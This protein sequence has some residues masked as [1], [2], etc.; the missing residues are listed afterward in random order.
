MMIMTTKM[1]RSTEAVPRPCRVLNLGTE[2]YLPRDPFTRSP[3]P[4]HLSL[5]PKRH[6]HSYHILLVRHSPAYLQVKYRQERQD[7]RHSR[8]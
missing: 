7:G 1:D 2:R 5:V 6:L 3:I 8:S 4:I